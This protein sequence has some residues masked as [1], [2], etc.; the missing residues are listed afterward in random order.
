[1]NVRAGGETGQVYPAFAR[2]LEAAARRKKT[3]ARPLGPAAILA[4][5]PYRQ[6]EKTK[7]SPAPAFHAAGQAVG[8]GLWSAYALFVAAYRDAA[9]SRR[10]EPVSV[11]PGGR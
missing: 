6:P 7:T 3:G 2:P 5:D 4:Q 9:T 1:M 8:R 11:A 10:V